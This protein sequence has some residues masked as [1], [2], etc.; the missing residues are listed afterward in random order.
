MKRG[1]LVD[2]S[3]R[4]LCTVNVSSSRNYEENMN[5]FLTVFRIED[6]S[7]D[8]PSPLTPLNRFSRFNLTLKNVN[9]TIGNNRHDMDLQAFVK[10]SP[11]PYFFNRMSNVRKLQDSGEF[12]PYI[13]NSTFTIN[14]GQVQFDIVAPQTSEIASV[15]RLIIPKTSIPHARI[16]L[17]Q[18]DQVRIF[19]S[20]SQLKPTSYIAKMSTGLFPN[21]TYYFKANTT[22]Q[23]FNDVQQMKPKQPYYCVD[24]T[25][26]P[27]ECP[28]CHKVI[29]EVNGTVIKSEYAYKSN[30][31]GHSMLMDVKSSY[32]DMIPVSQKTKDVVRR[33]SSSRSSDNL[34]LGYIF[35]ANQSEDIFFYEVGYLVGDK[36]MILMTNLSLPNTQ[37]SIYN[38]RVNV[39]CE[40]CL[41]LTDVSFKT[42]LGFTYNCTIPQ[43]W[44]SQATRA[45]AVDV[46]FDIKQ[47][48]GIEAGFGMYTAGVYQDFVMVDM[49]TRANISFSPNQSYLK[50]YFS[51]S[52]YA[53]ETGL[54]FTLM[55]EGIQDRPTIFYLAYPLGFHPG[56][57]WLSG[58]ITSSQ[59]IAQEGSDI[60]KICRVGET[61]DVYKGEMVQV[62]ILLILIGYY[63]TAK[64]NTK[65]NLR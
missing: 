41:V 51:E 3:N 43:R 8:F 39:T 33:Y 25:V 36:K 27:A 44:S 1:A 47:V 40:E 35:K 24:L 34:K 21:G 12:E 53:Y 22:K 30:W 57:A 62:N 11:E 31:Q 65:T 18:E 26:M 63:V 54:N 19:G 17:R 52:H 46:S 13:Q 15:Q 10:G 55:Q 60:T 7:S 4:R 59:Q 20:D 14:W 38:V 32:L 5:G 49:A 58:N 61:C 45:S 48:N 16:Q 2:R 50:T 29:L 64:P 28:V 37:P 56:A 6:M 23:D 9:S 42:G